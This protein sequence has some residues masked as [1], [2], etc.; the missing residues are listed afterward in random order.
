MS[1]WR[2]QRGKGMQRNTSAP[3]YRAAWKD[4]K[5]ARRTT[6]EGD[7]QRLRVRIGRAAQSGDER[8]VEAL[9]HEMLNSSVI[10]PSDLKKLSEL[11]R[12]LFAPTIAVDAL[13][14]MYERDPGNLAMLFDLASM[15]EF[16]CLNI[17]AFTHLEEA[18]AMCRSAT[19]FLRLGE[20]YN[21]LNELEASFAAC[22]RAVE[23]DPN[24][25]LAQYSLAVCFGFLG[26]LDEAE[27]I[28]TNLIANDFQKEFAVQNRAWLRRQ[29]SERN[30]VQELRKIIQALPAGPTSAPE[31]LYG[32]GKEL[33]DLGEATASFEEY[34]A[35][36]T[37]RRQSYTKFSLER[38]LRKAEQQIQN[39][40]PEFFTDPHEG[41]PSTEPIFVVSMPRA[42]STLLEQILGRHS[43]VFA[44]GELDCFMRLA[45]FAATQAAREAEAKDAFKPDWY[46]KLAFR[47]LGEAYIRATRPRTGH[48]PHFVD[49]LP[50][51]YI[52]CG[53]IACALPDAKIIHI[54]REPMDAC[55]AMYKQF[56]HNTYKFTYDQRELGSVYAAY[57]RLMDHWDKVMPGRII[58]VAYEELVN[59]T[60]KVTRDLISRLGLPWED[61]CLD[62]AAD[63]GPSKTASAVQVRQPVYKTS[64][65]RWRSVAH[66]LG[67]LIETLEAEGI[68]T[69]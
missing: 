51:N 34:E 38:E 12:Q 7:L 46:T 3:T 58:H 25:R 21:K 47:D 22:E 52:F 49:K 36:A 17:E 6:P 37:A 1:F 18:A 67:P 55:F 24:N 42:G 62:H 66:R 31:I 30:H 8:E 64:V 63:S 39:F 50:G 2:V 33:E 11:G 61:A 44:A 20:E 65:G 41:H 5:L 15:E 27:T 69:D 28:Y 4:R 57:R 29:T 54:H 9:A 48:T 19:D 45:T 56:F 68:K 53:T 60:E 23:I 16:F 26:N 40:T 59:D 14:Q 13:R 43:S 10:T 32:L 35:A